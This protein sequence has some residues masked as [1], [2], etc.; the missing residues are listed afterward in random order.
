MRE[1]KKDSDLKKSNFHLILI[2]K[3]NN[4]TKFVKAK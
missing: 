3:F 2:S 1:S 4:K